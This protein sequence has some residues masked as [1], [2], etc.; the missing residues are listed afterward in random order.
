MI[1]LD[2]GPS[3]M[4]D[5]QPQLTA[6]LHHCFAKDLRVIG[7][8]WAGFDSVLLGQNEFDRVARLH[9]KTYGTDYCYLGYKPGG[10]ANLLN[11]GTG[12]SSVYPKNVYNNAL[13]YVPMIK[14][15]KN[16]YHISIVIDLVVVG[17]PPVCIDYVYE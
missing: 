8:N 2:Y 13:T 14:P 15:I 17:S 10:L 6:L 12:I 1:S 3:S 9:G 4:A 7:I 11:M 16:Y 5:L